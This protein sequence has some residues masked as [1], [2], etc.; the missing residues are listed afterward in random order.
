MI[1]T[2]ASLPHD[3][4]VVSVIAATLGHTF[5]SGV[6]EVILGSVDLLSLFPDTLSP[7][8]S[9]RVAGT[10]GKSGPSLSLLTISRESLA[11]ILSLLCQTGLVEKSSATDQYG[12]THDRVQQ[13]AKSLLPTGKQGQQIIAALGNLILELSEQNPSEYWMLYT[14]TNLLLENTEGET[15]RGTKLA[16]LCVRAAK[17]A[18]SQAAFKVGAKYADSGIKA[19]GRGGWLQHYDLYLELMN[20]SAELHFSNGSFKK[21]KKRVASIQQKAKC[22]EDKTRAFHVILRTLKAADAV[23]EIVQGVHDLGFKCPK[24]ATTVT[25][26]SHLLKT[27]SLA[28][29]IEPSA[30]KNL[31]KMTDQKT[32]EATKL[33]GNMAAFAFDAGDENRVLTSCLQQFQ[34]TLKHGI[35]SSAPHAMAAYGVC[36]AHLGEIEQ[37]YE[38]GKEALALASGPEFEIGAAM[39]SIPS[40]IILWHL[41]HPLRESLDGLKKGFEDGIRFGDTYHGMMAARFR[42][43]MGVLVGNSLHTYER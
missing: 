37:A 39:T 29:K 3:A 15:V 21:C 5:N 32:I 19:L 14:A 28:R 10:P 34:M 24:K 25:I 35:S 17:K 33:L 36:L 23:R 22:V 4:Q 8:E 16:I 12:F 26:V 41:K 43:P 1:Q 31:P 9:E 7:T 20:L 27:K 38:Y 30:I 42:G 6:L 11:K 13:S 40:Y 18:S 2:I